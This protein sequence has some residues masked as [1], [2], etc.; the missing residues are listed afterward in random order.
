MGYIGQAG[1]PDLKQLSWS[2]WFSGNFQEGFQKSIES[3]VGFKNT[4]TRLRNQY[5]YSLFGMTNA[6]R[7]LAGYNDVLFEDEYI[8]EYTG[9]YFIGRAPI[10][11][12][13]DQLKDIL[14][15]LKSL[16]IDL[17][18]VFLPGK[19]SFF[20]E[21][22]PA[23][24]HPER[25]SLSNYEYFRMRFDQYNIPYL[26]LSKYF[27][28]AKDTCRFPL[29]P[30][31]GMH[32]STYGMIKAM[33]TLLRF[34]EKI[35]QTKLPHIWIKRVNVSD[36]VPGDDNDIGILLNLIFPLRYAPTA[37]PQYSV[38]IEPGQKKL[39]VLVVS[40]SYYDLVQKTIALDIFSE[41]EYWYYNDW[42]K[43]GPGVS[44]QTRLDKSDLLNK[45]GQF[46]VILL[47]SSDMNLHSGFFN[48]I[49]DTYL[50][51]H[52]NILE[53]P[54]LRY[55]NLVRGSREWFTSIVENANN[56][57]RTIEELTTIA[58][59]YEFNVDFPQLKNKSS[60]DSIEYIA[61]NI[62][63]DPEAFSIISQKALKLKIP[64][65]QMLHI[66][67]VEQYSKSKKKKE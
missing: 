8:F 6:G 63:S 44:D 41:N 15:L 37:Y 33:D 1:P 51:L 66:D 13:V 52:P 4:L 47:M 34:T 49:E 48:F 9:K 16:D 45:L 53:N 11:R 46:D 14:P 64:V 10:D 25:R 18:P 24:F 12:K 29:F 7:F 21:K 39:K 60:E 27:L 36:T 38:V 50:A 57:G 22:I 58:A 2:S 40:D 3:H 42:L 43:S 62:R 23:H 19:A 20:P 61:N 54:V 17:I 28:G 26:D 55:E 59:R 5:D 30:K 67:A 31:F 32:W 35:H 65:E 56:S